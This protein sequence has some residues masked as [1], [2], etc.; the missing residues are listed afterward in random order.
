MEIIESDMIDRKDTV[1]LQIWIKTKG[2]T[3]AVSL[4]KQLIFWSKT[5]DL[6]DNL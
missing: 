4:R 2:I 1:K 6:T 3:M 5:S